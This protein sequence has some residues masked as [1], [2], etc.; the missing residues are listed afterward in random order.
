MRLYIIYKT[1]LFSFVVATIKKAFKKQNIT[2][3]LDTNNVASSQSNTRVL[4]YIYILYI[5]THMLSLSL[6]FSLYIST[7]VFRLCSKNIF[8]ASSL[9]DLR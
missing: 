4:L 6:S 7:H 1:S 2:N 9:G 5:Y 8:W 3:R